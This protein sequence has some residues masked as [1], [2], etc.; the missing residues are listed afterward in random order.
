M[1]NDNRQM[2]VTHQRAILYEL[3]EIKKLLKEIV[4]GIITSGELIGQIKLCMEEDKRRKEKTDQFFQE[5]GRIIDDFENGHINLK[6]FC[7]R[8]KPWHDEL[9]DLIK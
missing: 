9:D 7:S 3:K 1:P 8:C 2:G 4:D 6:G 5:F